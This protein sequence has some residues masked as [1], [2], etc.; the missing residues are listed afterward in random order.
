[1]ISLLTYPDI[2]YTGIKIALINSSP[3]LQLWVTQHLSNLVLDTNIV[4]YDLKLD[5]TPLD[6]IL[7]VVESSD[8]V[9]YNTPSLHNWIA[10]YLLAQF[11]CYYLATDSS[12]VNTIYKISLRQVDDTNIGGVINNAIQKRSNAT[13]QFL[14]EVPC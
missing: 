13:L 1:M 4:V 5:S 6:Y 2:S 7:A 3:D 9:I 10:G 8:I 11:K 12:T 14:P